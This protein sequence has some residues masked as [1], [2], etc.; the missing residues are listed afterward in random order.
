[1][2]S[3]TCSSLDAVQLLQPGEVHPCDSI[4]ATMGF[5][6]LT[7]RVSRAWLIKIRSL[8]VYDRIAGAHHRLDLNFQLN[9]PESTLVTMPHGIMGQSWDGDGQPVNGRMDEYP[10]T[11]GAVFTTSAMAE[12]ARSRA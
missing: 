12:G 8:P 7:V 1:M 9:V 5:S 4:L 3:A 11:E 10:H 2:V 6:T